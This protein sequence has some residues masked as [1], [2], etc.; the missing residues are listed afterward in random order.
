M[1]ITH[2]T[3]TEQ[4]QGVALTDAHYE[5]CAYSLRMDND[6]ATM[7]RLRGRLAVCT[8]IMSSAA[9]VLATIEPESAAESEALDALLEQ[10]KTACLAIWTDP[11]PDAVITQNLAAAAPDLLTVLQEVQACAAYWSEYDVPLGM[12][13]RIKA[14]IAKATGG[15]V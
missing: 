12:A 10:I 8:D 11:A 3:P 15:E 9:A 6:E 1:S 13:Q 5:L 7:A 4:A 14:A 2:I